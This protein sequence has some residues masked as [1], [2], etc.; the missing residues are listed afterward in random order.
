MPKPGLPLPGHDA[1]LGKGRRPTSGTER[2]IW[3]L[4]MRPNGGAAAVVRPP[5][6]DRHP[7]VIGG[8]NPYLSR[9]SGNRKN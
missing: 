1:A 8:G 2:Y 4:C 6:V 3:C 5:Q 9:P 7:W